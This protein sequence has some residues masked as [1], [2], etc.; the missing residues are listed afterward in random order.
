MIPGFLFLFSKR[1]YIQF[2]SAGIMGGCVLV[3]NRI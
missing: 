2:S 1:C 3:Q